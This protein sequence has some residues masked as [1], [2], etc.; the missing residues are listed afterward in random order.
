MAK[1][2]LKKLERPATILAAIGA[3]NLGLAAIL[4]LDVLGM[5]GAIPFMTAAL[6]WILGVSGLV[7]LIVAIQAKIK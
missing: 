2:S 6:P 3:L 4:G 1:M 5:L 7:V